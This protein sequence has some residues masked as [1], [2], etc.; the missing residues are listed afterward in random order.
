MLEAIL[1]I[2]SLMNPEALLLLFVIPLVLA[3]EWFARAPGA[4]IISTGE[5]VAAI[6]AAPNAWR[7]HMPAVLRAIGLTLLI[8]ALARPLHGL[9]PR[10]EVADVVDI[11][12]CVDV[13]ESMRATDLSNRDRLAVTKIAVHDFIDSRKYDAT[14]RYGLDRLGLILYARVAWT[15]C[16]LTLD[17]A[18]LT[19]EL[20]GASAD[21]RDPRTG[22]TAI[23]SAIGLAVSKLKDSDSKSKVIVLL[24]DGR[25]NAGELDPMTAADFANEFG[26]RVY[27][28]GAGS[29]DNSLPVTRQLLGP[30][31]GM[32]G[33]APDEDMLRAIA[34]RTGGKFYRATDTDSLQGA[35]T[36]INELEKTTVEIGDYYDFEDGFLPFAICGFIAMAASVFSRRIWFETIP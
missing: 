22:A 24:T 3:A 25:N 36:E 9:T 27:T 15:Q 4:L 10:K 19:R 13:S 16:P 21:P 34:D 17:Y 30:M 31:A 32:R 8:I 26:I 33:N 7:R 35:Y 23:G 12:L 28:I 5:T 2:N 18:V 20:D 1:G 14:D 6:N 11:M 29:A